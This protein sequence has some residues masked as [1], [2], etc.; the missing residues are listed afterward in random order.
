MDKG[1]VKLWR[2]SLHDGWIRN[3]TVWIF[4]TYCLLKATHREY[5]AMIGAQT[6][7]L[8]PGQFVFGLCRAA[9]ETGLSIQ[10]IRTAIHYLEQSQNLTS[11][12][13]NKYSVITITNWDIY[14]ESETDNQQTDQ[15]TNNKQITTY[16]NNN[17]ITHNKFI[18]PNIEE[19]KTYCSTRKNT[20]NPQSFLDFYESNG[21]KVGKNPMKDW[22]AAIRTWETREGNNATGNGTTRR[23]IRTERD[24]LNQA[25]LDEADIIRREYEAKKAASTGNS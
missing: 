7:H 6:I 8:T 24:A 15:Q 2:K 23:Q 5:D 14:Q 10:K 12:T 19:I 20:I 18:K 1:Y 3:H 4:W 11:K 9:D 25:G 22:K 17:T 16:K 21:W 13:T